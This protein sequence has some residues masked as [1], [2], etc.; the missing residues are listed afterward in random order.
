MTDAGS[1]GG[2]INRID[3]IDAARGM[4][5]IA[6]VLFHVVLWHYLPEASNSRPFLYGMWKFQNDLLGSVRIPL[7]LTLSG[8]LAA[9]KISR[10]FR[11]L[12]AMTSTVVNYYF[13]VL[14]LSIYALFF[15]FTSGPLPHRIVSFP[16]FLRELL[17][18]DTTL[19]YVLALAVYVPL[20]T[21]VRRAPWWMIVLV[22]AILAIT[23][24]ESGRFSGMWAKLPGNALFFAVGVYASPWLK[25]L[26]TQVRLWFLGPLAL[27]PM[28]LLFADGRLKIPVL[29]D[30]L[31]LLAKLAFAALFLVA[32]ILVCRLRPVAHVGS[33]V[34]RVTLPIYVLHALLIYVWLLLIAGPLQ[35]VMTAVLGIPLLS[36]LYPAVVT[37]AIVA[38]TLVI[39][40][41]ARSGGFGFLFVA[42]PQIQRW[43][44]N[45]YERG[46]QRRAGTPT[47][48]EASVDSKET[49]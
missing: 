28:V 18:P 41:V 39:H 46:K 11:N 17:V 13:Y 19:W 21:L 1:P 6:V 36:A 48:G 42:P 37:A 16:I 32:V 35:D 38:I 27:L 8:V 25:E 20:M 49:D 43:V 5:V 22:L 30:V 3:W 44:A 34:G 4:S 9:N 14:W 26:A 29:G 10:G 12:G 45:A 2:T 33:V 40:R 15:L 47:V 24:G 7:L 23:F 31:G